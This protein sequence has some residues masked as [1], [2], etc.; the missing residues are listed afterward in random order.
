MG[1]IPSN[2]NHN[3]PL[4]ALKQLPLSSLSTTLRKKMEIKLSEQAIPG[5]GQKVNERTPLPKYF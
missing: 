1:E 5:E 4:A 3:L 2:T